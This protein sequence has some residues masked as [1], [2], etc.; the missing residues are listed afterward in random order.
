MTRAAPA[1]CLALYR[2]GEC[3][4]TW[5]GRQGLAHRT[6]VPDEE[7]LCAQRSCSGMQAGTLSNCPLTMAKLSVL[8]V[9]A[10]GSIIYYHSQIVLLKPPAE[11]LAQREPGECKGHEKLREQADEEDIKEAGPLRPVAC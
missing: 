2:P 8:L 3:A 5:H 6:P 9:K 4:S 1:A 11:P 7:A 10:R